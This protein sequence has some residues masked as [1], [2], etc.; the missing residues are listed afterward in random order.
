M[1]IVSAFKVSQ[2]GVNPSE[3]F[4]QLFKVFITASSA[5][6]FDMFLVRGRKEMASNLSKRISAFISEEF[7]EASPEVP[8]WNSEVRSCPAF[9]VNQLTIRFVLVLLTSTK[10]IILQNLNMPVDVRNKVSDFDNDLADLSVDFVNIFADLLPHH[11]FL[12]RL[13]VG[14]IEFVGKV[15]HQLITCFCEE[16]VFFKV[17]QGL[18]QI[19]PEHWPSFEVSDIL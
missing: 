9:F 1:R 11:Y 10:Q 5:E 8:F 15:S 7:H 6:H 17:G 13:P 19:L 16:K 4:V 12:L 14:S 3:S 18:V 2:V